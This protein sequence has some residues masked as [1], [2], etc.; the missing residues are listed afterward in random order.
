MQRGIS[1]PLKKLVKPSISHKAR[2]NRIRATLTI[3]RQHFPESG[4]LDFGT[5]FHMLVAVVLSARTRDEQVLQALPDFFSMFPDVWQL[6]RARVEE[7]EL[8]ISRIGLYKSKARYLVALAQHLCERFAGE[9]PRTMGELISLPGVGRKTASV[10]LAARFSLPA[11]AVDTHVFRIAQRL[12]WAKAASVLALEQKLVRIVPVD[13]QQAVN[14][15]MVP[16]GRKICV[17][18]TPRCWSCPVV[19]LCAYPQKSLQV[20]R[21]ADAILLRAEKQ[22]AEIAR[23]KN[24]CASSFS[25]E[26]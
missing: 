10:L 23:L 7:V 13:I 12:G 9:V 14:T 26:E 17:P 21:N 20:P 15:T 2:Q 18:G 1:F 16:F 4:A 25:P 24:I 11:L 8:Y 19:H 6:S 22:R 3:L 5:P